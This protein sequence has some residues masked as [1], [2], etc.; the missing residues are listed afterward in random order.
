MGP[1]DE[2]VAEVSRLRDN[3]LAAK[4]ATCS[5]EYVDRVMLELWE[6]GGR[7]PGARHRAPSRGHAGYLLGIQM[8]VDPRRAKG[9]CMDSV[10][11]VPPLC[12]AVHLDMVCLKERGHTGNHI[13]RSEGSG[14]FDM[15]EWE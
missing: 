3:G 13:G 12:S 11:A 1:I 8:V 2:F 10:H 4:V 7:K 9:F 15:A 6:Q 14:M 5:A